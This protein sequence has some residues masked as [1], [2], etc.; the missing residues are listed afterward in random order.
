MGVEAYPQLAMKATALLESVA[1]FQ[2]LIDGNK[3]T[4]WTL[5]VLM[6]WING[7]RH[8]FSPDE[9]FNLVVGAAT[10]AVRLVGRPL[11]R[12]PRLPGSLA[13]SF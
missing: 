2:P 8:D 9:A 11:T 3:P 5:M 7:Y 13:P 10:R 12:R 6:F 1:R 4:T